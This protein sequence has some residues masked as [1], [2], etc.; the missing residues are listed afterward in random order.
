MHQAVSI[1]QTSLKNSH[2]IA[3]HCEAGLG[4]TGTI[5]AAFL[6]TCG[7]HAEE[8]ID[9]IRKFRPGSVETEEQEAIIYKYEHFDKM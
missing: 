4:R 1:I 5:I 2:P 3:V 8:A 7:L 9:S 6:T